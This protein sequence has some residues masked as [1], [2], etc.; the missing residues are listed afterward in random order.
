MRVAFETGMRGEARRKSGSA[1]LRTLF[2]LTPD[3]PSLYS[4]S[5]E[6]HTLLPPGE[7]PGMRGKKELNS[8]AQGD[9]PFLPGEGAGL[10]LVEG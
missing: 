4:F 3:P 9:T 6:T 8:T 5:V 7:G 2:A 1:L 10:R